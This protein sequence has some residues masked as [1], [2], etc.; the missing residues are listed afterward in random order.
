MP[1][2][3]LS[4]CCG[5]SRA[6][7]IY[8]GPPR[9]APAQSNSPDTSITPAGDPGVR[10]WHAHLCR[11]TADRKLI[12]LSFKHVLVEKPAARTAA[13]LGPV[14]EAERASGC[15]PPRVPQGVRD[16]APAPW[17]RSCSSAAA[18]GHGGRIGYDREWRARRERSGGGELIDQGVH[19]VDL[20][21]CFLGELP[22]VQGY[23]PT[24]FWDMEV[25]DNGFPGA[26]AISSAGSRNRSRPR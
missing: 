6:R 20:A 24:Y 4:P 18:T 12:C 15:R 10:R 1:F 5:H 7:P 3:Q 14:I 17:A 16:R 23:A 11:R 19:L 13:E 2:W 21:R 26:P 22:H 25:E 9:P 8:M